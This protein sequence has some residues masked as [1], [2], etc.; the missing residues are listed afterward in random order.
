MRRSIF[1]WW[2][3]AIVLLTGCGDSGGSG[4]D[5]D[6]CDAPGQSSTC[7]CNGVMIG[8]RRCN[9]A[10]IWDECS[11]P[12]A[13]ALDPCADP[14][15]CS[16]CPGEDEGRPATCVQTDAGTEFECSCSDDSTPVDSMDASTD[17]GGP[18]STPDGGC[19]RAPGPLFY[20]PPRTRFRL[21]GPG[22]W[23]RRW[24]PSPEPSR[25]GPA[26]RPG[27]RPCKGPRPGTWT[28]SPPRRWRRWARPRPGQRTPPCGASPAAFP[29]RWCQGRS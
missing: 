9:E 12:D 17:G 10:N 6:A 20:P 16:A 27:G 14:P 2:T 22:P 21:P 5:G 26:S 15:L 28:A 7:V 23:R 8:T 25:P 18:T 19:R 4:G 29:S 24:W 3:V 13:A 11:C 1:S